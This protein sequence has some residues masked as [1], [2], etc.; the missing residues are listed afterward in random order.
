MMYV[1]E[2]GDGWCSGAWGSHRH[3]LLSGGVQPLHG[4]RVRH[5]GISAKWWCKY[6][7]KFSQTVSGI[8]YRSAIK[9][10]Y[11]IQNLASFPRSQYF[12]IGIWEHASHHVTVG[13]KQMCCYWW[14]FVGP[15]GH[16][17][18]QPDHRTHDL[19]HRPRARWRGAADGPATDSGGPGEHVGYRK[20]EF[21]HYKLRHRFILTMTWPNSC[22]LHLR[23]H[24][25][26]TSPWRSVRTSAHP[27]LCDCSNCTHA[28]QTCNVSRLLH[29]TVFSIL[30]LKIVVHPNKGAVLLAGKRHVC[31]FCTCIEV[32]TNLKPEPVFSFSISTPSISL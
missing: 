5:A 18:D 23:G 7:D 28:L 29:H 19:W 8:L 22:L 31:A 2:T 13:Y 26:C 3:L 14:L 21:V 30:G 24:K 1:Y 32:W 12:V 4:T 6:V 11:K 15:P 17:P 20:C 27:V 10:L 16:P 9:D 25:I